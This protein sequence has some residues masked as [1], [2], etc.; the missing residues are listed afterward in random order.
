MV[1]PTRLIMEVTSVSDAEIPVYLKANGYES[2]GERLASGESMY[3]LR[4]VAGIVLSVGLLISVLSVYLLMLSIYLLL[5]KNT[6]QLESLLLLG[7]TR[8]ELVRPYLALTFFA[9]RP[10]YHRFA[11]GCRRGAGLLSSSSRTVT[12]R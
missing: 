3:L 4:L 1:R 2:E 8:Q 7:Y 5:Q 6:K 10:C 11:C 9:Q 12:L